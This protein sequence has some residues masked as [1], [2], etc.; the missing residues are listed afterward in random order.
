VKLPPGMPADQAQGILTYLKTNP[1]AAK[2][3]W[4]QAQA[5]MQ[6]P[7]LA[8]QFINMSVSG[9]V[10][11]AG[12]WWCG[13]PCHDQQHLPLHPV[14]LSTHPPPPLHPLSGP[15]PPP[16]QANADPARSTA[17]YESLK[18]DPEL[19]HV[20]DDVKNNGPG[21]LQK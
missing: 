7:G 6:S 21:A 13:T 9:T 14:N 12:H 20:F 11:A 2:A 4:A 19:S 5:I 16:P 18:D 17:V 3:A 15:P 1:E 8:N 10:A